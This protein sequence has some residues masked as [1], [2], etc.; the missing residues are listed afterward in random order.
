MSARNKEILAAGAF[1]AVFAVLGCRLCRNRNQALQLATGV[2]AYSAALEAG[3]YFVPGRSVSALDLL[4]NGLG[5]VVG[6]MLAIHATSAF[7]DNPIN[8]QGD[9]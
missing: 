5:V 4:A 3:Q 6:V 1:V 8:Q 9:N 7:A 2:F